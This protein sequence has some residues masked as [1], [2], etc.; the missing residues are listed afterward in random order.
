MTIPY[1]CSCELE[2]ILHIEF[3]V[4]FQAQFV[5]WRMTNKQTKIVSSSYKNI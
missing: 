5:N 3:F 4:L 2:I 1:I